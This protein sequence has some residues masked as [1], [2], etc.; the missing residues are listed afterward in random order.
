VHIAR[1]YG[2]KFTK[3]TF[4]KQDLTCSLKKRPARLTSFCIFPEQ[5]NQSYVPEEEEMNRPSHYERLKSKVWLIPI[6]QLDIDMGK[7]V[8]QG[9]YGPVVKGAVKTQNDHHP[10]N[11]V[12]CIKGKSLLSTCE[13]KSTYVDVPV[14]KTELANWVGIY[15]GWSV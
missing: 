2:S 3:V 6:N 13:W 5:E 15:K 8:G 4:R 9:S 1:S 12:Y 14:T 10:E 11:A 7:V